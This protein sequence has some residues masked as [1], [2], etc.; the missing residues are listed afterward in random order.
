MEKSDL[1]DPN[2][3]DEIESQ[4]KQWL[5]EKPSFNLDCYYCIFEI[6]CEDAHTSKTGEKECLKFRGA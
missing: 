3:Q 6:T 2:E 4:Y 1:I 5:K